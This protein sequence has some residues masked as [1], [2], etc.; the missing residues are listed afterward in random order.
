MLGVADTLGEDTVSNPLPFRGASVLGVVDTLDEDTVSNPATYSWS[1]S[2]W[3][4]GY[5]WRR[6]RV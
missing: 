1:V 5:S 3:R 6:H 2:A 4:R